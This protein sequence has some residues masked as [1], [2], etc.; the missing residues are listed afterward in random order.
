MEYIEVLFIYE[1][2]TFYGALKIYFIFILCLWESL[3]DELS[4]G[5]SDLFVEF[6]I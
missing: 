4:G 2:F 3:I 5:Y 6:L 1:I